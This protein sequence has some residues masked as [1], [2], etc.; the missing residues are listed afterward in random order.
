M[1]PRAGG[2]WST[3]SHF[4]L[5]F[6]AAWLSLNGSVPRRSPKRNP[7]TKFQRNRHAMRMPWVKGSGP[8]RESLNRWKSGIV[9]HWN[10]TELRT[11][12]SVCDL[13]LL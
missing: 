9:T 4:L 1:A 11:H 5:P 3:A 12:V 10:C 6:G 7:F 8:V 2:R 13:E